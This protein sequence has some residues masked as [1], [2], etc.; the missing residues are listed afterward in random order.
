MATLTI[1]NVDAAVHKALRLRAAEQGR[2]VEEEVRRI[3]A[4]R[5]SGPTE[6]RNPKSPEEIDQAVRSAQELFAPLR[7]TYS[8]DRFIAEKRAEA[9][10]DFAE[11][12]VEFKKAKKFKK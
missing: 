11:E 7:K 1:R 4:E 2:S 5:V 8:V 10:R 6:Y 3:L 12:P 9:A